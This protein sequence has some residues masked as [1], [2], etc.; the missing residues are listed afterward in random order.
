V[1]WSG[2]GTS[3][4]YSRKTNSESPP[5]TTDTT[6]VNDVVDSLET[7]LRSLESVRPKH[8]RARIY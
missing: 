8:Y 3:T 6:L 1:I 5:R 7:Y 2:I 4:G